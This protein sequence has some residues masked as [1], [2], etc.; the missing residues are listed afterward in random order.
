MRFIEKHAIVKFSGI[1]DRDEAE[2]LKG[3]FVM[4]PE[5][6]L[7]PLPEDTYHVFDLVGLEVRT[8]NNEVVGP[9]IDI[10]HMPAHD[11]YVVDRDGSECMIPAVKAFIRRVAVEE[12]FVEVNVIEGLLD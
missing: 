8:T 5:D 2:T 11:V 4:L 3:A 7:P 1:D 6:A 9:I 10:M 12:G